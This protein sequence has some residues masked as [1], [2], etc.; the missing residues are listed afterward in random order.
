M[1]VLRLLMVL[2]ALLTAQST[3]RVRVGSAT[4]AMPLERYVAGVLAGESSVFRSDEALKAMAVAARTYAVRLR[5]R[6]AAEGFDFCA[7]THCQR[8]DP[9]AITPRLEWI[10]AET[11]GELLWFEGK[12]AFT[13]YTRDCGGRTEDGGAVWPDVAAPYLKSREDPHGASTWQWSG[14]P[15]RVAEALRRSQL[16]TPRRVERISISQR[17]ESGRARTLVLFGEGESVHISAGSFRFA[18]GRELGWNTVLSD[19]YE[20]RLGTVFEG[21]GS[22]HGVGLCQRGADQMGQA[23]HIYHEILAFYYPGT[24]PG[25]NGRGL[26]WQRLGGDTVALLS[27]RPDQDRSVLAL[28]EREAQSVS[29]RAN[30]SL[31]RGV[32]IRVYP[33]VE[34]FR[35]VTGEPGWV[36]AYTVGRRIHLQ[37][38]VVLRSRGVLD[39]TLRHELWHV[40]VEARASA[41]LPLWFREGLVEYLGGAHDASNPGTR[42]PSD[43]ALRQTE[44]EVRA[45]RAYA[46]AARG[47]A[48][49]VKRYGETTVLEWLKTG[50]PAEVKK[51]SSSQDA[52]KSK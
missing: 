29:R 6:H 39:E 15:A 37:P 4:I 23:G 52:T 31:P 34:T 2:P 50:L 18:L 49:V 7:T 43:S 27:T 1:R 33:D 10:A 11:A 13:P 47:V 24:V 38:A 8:V 12:P 32:E 5:G 48:A 17:T 14:D 35:N 26:S 9:D 25:L 19:R 46:D 16:R 42:M 41:G 21:Q 20:I 22:G 44:D 40:L 36:A 3:V 45:R 28:A 51:A 30:L